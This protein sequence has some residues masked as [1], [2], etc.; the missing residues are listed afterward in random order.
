MI[1]PKKGSFVNKNRFTELLFIFFTAAAIF[2]ALILPISLRPAPSLLKIGDVAFQDIRAPRSFSYISE[3]LTE[4]ARKD[5]EKTVVPIYL[6]ADP[7]ISR[8]Q[9]DKLSSVLRYINSIR[10]DSFASDDQKKEDLS[11]FSELSLNE[12]TILSLLSLSPEKWELIKNESIFILE[13]VMKSSIREDQLAAIRR[14]LFPRIGFE[15]NETEAGIINELV[16]PLI[17]ANSDFSHE[18]TAKAID[19][20]RA[21]IETVSKQ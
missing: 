4:T 18:N 17:T 12:E 19:N 14:N 10:S 15:F 8:R 7:I 2:L 3:I 9:V 1:S 11:S 21:V 6:P 5:A 13:E 16:S 20:A